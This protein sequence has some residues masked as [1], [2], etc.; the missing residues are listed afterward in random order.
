MIN[1]KEQQWKNLQKVWELVHNEKAFKEYIHKEI[2][3]YLS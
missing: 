3:A 1:G 2:K